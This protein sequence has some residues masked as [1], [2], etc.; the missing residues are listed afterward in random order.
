[1]ADEISTGSRPEAAT[2]GTTGVPT[3]PKVT[4][5]MWPTM[6]AVTAETAD[7]PMAMRNGAA[8]AAEVPKPAAPSSSSAKNQATT[9]AVRRGSD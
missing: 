4:P 5:R 6:A 1:M 8:S 2:M 3:A 9:R 7:M